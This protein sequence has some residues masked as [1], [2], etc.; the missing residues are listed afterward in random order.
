M[1]KPREFWIKE[2]IEFKTDTEF[3]DGA[4][5]REAYDKPEPNRKIHV[6]EYS[7]YL[8]AVEI[9]KIQNEAMKRAADLCIE[10][11]RTACVFDARNILDIISNQVEENF[12]K[13]IED[14]FNR[15]L[16]KS[17]DDK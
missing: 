12:I 6:I 7:E 5:A 8:S 4:N 11:I 9:I 15:E 14:K 3:S 17:E 10:P 1:D 2:Y 13:S 16:F